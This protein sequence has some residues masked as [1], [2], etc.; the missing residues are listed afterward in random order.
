MLGTW[1]AYLCIGLYWA[2]NLYWLTGDR[3]ERK[4]IRGAWLFFELA[5]LNLLHGAGWGYIMF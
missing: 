1:C 5:V 2:W 4:R 3:L